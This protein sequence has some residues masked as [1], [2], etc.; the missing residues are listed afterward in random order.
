[1]IGMPLPVRPP[2][3][4]GWSSGTVARPLKLVTMPKPISSSFAAALPACLAPLPSH[5]IGRFAAITR[6]ASSS[7]SASVGTRGAGSGSTKLSS[8]AGRSIFARCR[9]IGTS[10]LTGPIG[11]LSASIAAWVS[12]PSAFCAE[13]MR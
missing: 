8:I 11:A 13:R 5:S 12:M 7:S 3:L 6:A 9:S 2:R 1:M 10:T 4:R